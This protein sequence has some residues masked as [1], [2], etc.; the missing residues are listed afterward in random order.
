MKMNKKY[1]R[2]FPYKILAHSDKL[3]AIARGEI[4]YPIIMHIYPTNFC[5]NNCSF[6][7]MKKEKNKYPVQLS[8]KTLFKAVKSAK[9]V[10]VKL[11]HFSGG[12]EPTLHPNIIDAMQLARKLGIK[13]AISTNGSFFSKELPKVANHIRVSIN[14]GTIKTYKDDMKPKAH[15]LIQVFNNVEKYV[16]IRNKNKYDCDIGTGFVL[17]YTNFKDIYQ[18]CKKSNNANA[19]FVHIRPAFLE[20]EDDKIKDIMDDAFMQSEHAKRSFKNLEIFT[21]KDKFEGYWTPRIYDKCRS[22]PLIAVLSATGEFIV[23]QDV[24][25][26]FGNLNTENIEKIWGSKEHKKAINKIKL[27]NCPRCVENNINEIIQHCFIN[28]EVRMDL[29]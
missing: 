23:C 25:I 21:I 26:R 12:G 8:K 11:I 2:F 7:I 14:A 19:D 1:N 15:G 18:F 13:T 17:S 24:F 10:G 27:N 6:C 4:P 16:K 5:N 3:E 22:T 9:R 20:N 28:D 29:I